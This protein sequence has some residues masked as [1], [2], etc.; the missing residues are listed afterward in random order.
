MTRADKLQF[1]AERRVVLHRIKQELEA[2]LPKAGFKIKRIM[3][4]GGVITIDTYRKHEKGLGELMTQAGFT[5][6]YANNI[7]H[8]DGY[9]GFRM[10]FQI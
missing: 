4:A 3:V 10:R 8:L 2:K 6:T 5:C 9:K 1:L 7:K